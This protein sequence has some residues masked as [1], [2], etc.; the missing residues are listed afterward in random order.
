MKHM[1]NRGNFS[2]SA[3]SHLIPS[4]VIGLG[5]PNSCC[6]LEV[7]GSG[8][9]G[10]QRRLTH[11]VNLIIKR[12]GVVVVRIIPSISSHAEEECQGDDQRQIAPAYVHVGA[13][14]N[15]TAPGSQ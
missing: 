9:A 6:V 11:V 10:G 4:R 2:G 14:V 15:L 5:G 8:V 7:P 1:R 12:F 13:N 3:I